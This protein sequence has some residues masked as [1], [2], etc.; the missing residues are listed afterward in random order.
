MDTALS[1]RRGLVWHHPSCPSLS[2]RSNT[3]SPPQ[4]L[5]R[6]R[7]RLPT[8]SHWPAHP[9]ASFDLF[10]YPAVI[11]AVLSFLIKWLALKFLFLRLLWGEQPRPS[12]WSQLVFYLDP[13]RNI[14]EKSKDSPRLRK[15]PH[16]VT[17]VAEE[18]APPQWSLGCLSLQRHTQARQLKFFHFLLKQ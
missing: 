8:E 17:E 15:R 16:P 14:T 10:L 2:L 9:P 3:E 6:T 7:L 18:S 11:F 5:S 12:Q 1:D 4:W 13:D